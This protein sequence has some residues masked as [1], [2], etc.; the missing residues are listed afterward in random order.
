MPDNDNNPNTP[1][2]PE[3]SSAPAE[4]RESQTGTAVQTKPAPSKPKPKQLPP[5]KVILH[6]DDVND[7]LYVIETV[8]MLTTLD[9][10]KA[11]QCVAEAHNSGLSLLLTTHQERAELY[12]TQFASRNLTVTIEPE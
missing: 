6:N 2:T 5:W 12:Q 7:I 11:T 4:P 1:E 10:K 3:K 9:K 8:L